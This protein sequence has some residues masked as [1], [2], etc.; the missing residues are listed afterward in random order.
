MPKSLTYSERARE[1]LFHGVE[2]LANAVAVTLGP[3]GRN[4]II[5]RKFGSPLITKDGVSVAKEID[6]EDPYENMGAQL[7]KEAATRTNDLAGDGTTT[8]TVLAYA[9]AKEGVKMVAAGYDPISIKRGIDEG[10]NAAIASL[11]EI[12]QD[13]STKEDIFNVATIS[14]NGD[15]EIGLQI[16]DAM[17]HVG[18]DGVVT[19]EESRTVDTYVEY[20]E[21]MQFDRGY[22]SPYFATDE[23]MTATL[24]NPYILV[25]NRSIG[26]IKSIIPLL[27]MVQR[28]DKPLFIVADNVEGPVLQALIINN[29]KGVLHS[30]VVRSPGYGERRFELLKDIAILTGAKYVDEDAGDEFS[31]LSLE[32]LGRAERV[33]VT[34]D[35]TTIINGL[36][37]EEALRARI[38]NLRILANETTSDYDREKY[39]ERIAKLSGGVA[40]LNVGAASEV[41]MKEKKH[42]V[43][44]ALSATR[45]ALL[46]G[47]VPGGGL[48]LIKARM[49]IADRDFDTNV[50]DGHLAGFRI[51]LKALEEPMW[52]IAEN[53]GVSGDV[54]VATAKERCNSKHSTKINAETGKKVHIGYD[55]ASGEWVDMFEAGIIDPYNVTRAALQNAG[56][57]AGMLLT[58]ECAIVSLPEKQ[59]PLPPMPQM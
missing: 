11:D 48:A 40:V 38:E 35:S 21:G 42:R 34:Q 39:Q 29:L 50:S 52:K 32:D 2:Q 20:V 43:E 58:T 9:I 28:A 18:K 37:D 5:D 10:I 30:C 12:R 33:K 7:I 17:E 19:V 49:S 46:G 55:A 16:A 41:E 54:V 1:K 22:M 26:N 15:T 27:E 53:A 57:V 56:S 3:R 4:V 23:H 44:D 51:V 13:I 36:G 14:A 24:E 45:A 59:E 25:T 6:V 8:A 31:S 47:I